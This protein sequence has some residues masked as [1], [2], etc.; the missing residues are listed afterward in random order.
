MSSTI[1]T[2]KLNNG[3]SMPLFGLGT[4]RVFN[5]SL[6]Y[7]LVIP[8]ISGQCHLVLPCFQTQFLNLILLSVK[9]TLTLNIAV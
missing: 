5:S 4:W 1:P 3:V 7:I 9:L 8:L 2:L 6:N